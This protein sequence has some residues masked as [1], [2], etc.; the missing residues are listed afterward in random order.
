M[1]KGGL[2]I[3]SNQTWKTTA[4]I[5]PTPAGYSHSIPVKAGGYF[6]F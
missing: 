3:I 2:F 1:T 4:L 6:V 5:P